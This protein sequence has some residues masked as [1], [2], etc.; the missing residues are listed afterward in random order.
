[1]LFRMAATVE[2][3]ARTRLP[4]IIFTFSQ[5]NQFFGSPLLILHSH[6]G[7]EKLWDIRYPVIFNILIILNCSGTVHPDDGESRLRWTRDSG[8][9]RPVI[10][11]E[12]VTGDL[13]SRWMIRTEK[14]S[15]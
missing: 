6:E 14:P 11:E 3:R 13:L 10:S 5:D 2:T 4:S 8:K 1:M 7:T 9:G 15:S 12:I